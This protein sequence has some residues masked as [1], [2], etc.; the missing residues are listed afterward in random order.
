MFVCTL[1]RSE[2]SFCYAAELSVLP[3]GALYGCMKQ[4][5]GIKTLFSDPRRRV[6]MTPP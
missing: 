1:L 3:G 2:K 6:H 4:L 5:R